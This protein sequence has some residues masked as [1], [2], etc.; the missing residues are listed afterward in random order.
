MKETQADT[1]AKWFWGVALIDAE[2]WISLP[3]SSKAIFGSVLKMVRPIGI[4]HYW[5]RWV[6][7]FVRGSEGS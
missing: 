3:F 4:S 5:L 7:P 6:M 1:F 2:S